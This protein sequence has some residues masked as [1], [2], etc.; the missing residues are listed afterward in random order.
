MTILRSKTINEMVVSLVTFDGLNGVIEYHIVVSRPK[1]GFYKEFVLHELHI[2]ERKFSILV[3]AI[4]KY[5]QSRSN[6]AILQDSK[7]D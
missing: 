5:Y 1:T 3:K 7:G 6:S 4:E 2:A